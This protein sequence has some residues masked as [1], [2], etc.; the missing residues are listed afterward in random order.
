VA[1]QDVY[2][3]DSLSLP[4]EWVKLFN[5]MITDPPYREHVHANATSQSK[6][7][8]T[9]HRDLGFEHLSRRARQSV[10][11]YAACVKRWSVVYS[12]VEASALLRWAVEAR[13]VE[14]IRTMPWVRWSMPNL[15]GDR[16]PQGF[17]HILVFHPRGRKHWSGPGNLISLNHLSVRGKQHQNETKH[18]CQKPLDQALDLVSWFSDIGETI[19]DPFAG[20][21]TI[22]VACRLL[23]RNYVGFELDPEWA[24][25]AQK[26][27][28]G[29]PGDLDRI[30]R[31][32]ET[33]S[34]PV[35]SLS[36]GPSLERAR[37][38]A[39]DKENVMR[40]VFLNVA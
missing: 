19:F 26:R 15:Q 5:V 27:L 29:D 13:R 37:K 17:E 11:N 4:P 12:D 21:G 14:Y 8:G 32:L 22:G 1:S 35:S 33:D 16:P 40:G 3:R 10:A 39:Q 18:K 24:L 9:R 31:W 7:R 20:S 25:K 34:E 2:N 38:R 30:V 36:E 23:G 28:I 6:G